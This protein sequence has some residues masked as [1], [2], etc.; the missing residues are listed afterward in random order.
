MAD[1]K[2]GWAAICEDAGLPNVTPHSL[3]HTAITWAMQRGARAW[4]AS[5]FFGVSVKVIEEV[6]GH[7][8]DDHQESARA[9]MDKRA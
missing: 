4:D 9:A 3:R 6:Y 7:H 1:I 8:A 2:T 5:G